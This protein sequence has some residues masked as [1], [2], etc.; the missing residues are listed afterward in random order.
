MRLSLRIFRISKMLLNACRKTFS[1]WAASFMHILYWL[2]ILCCAE[3]DFSS[4]PY[5]SCK[6][7]KLFRFV[8]LRRRSLSMSWMR[9]CIAFK[10]SCKQKSYPIEWFC[11]NKCKN[12][13]KLLE[14]EALRLLLLMAYRR[15]IFFCDWNQLCWFDFAGRTTKPALF[16]F[17]SKIF[18]NKRRQFDSCHFA[19]FELN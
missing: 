14:L 4:V 12:M 13:M 11:I 18:V 9:T 10:R 1:S 3:F 16:D 8:S 15:L 17:L 19:C 7:Y 2:R 6:R 5:F